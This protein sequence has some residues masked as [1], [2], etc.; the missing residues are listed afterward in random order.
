MGGCEEARHLTAS[1]A[2]SSRPYQEYLEDPVAL[3]SIRTIAVFPFED[4]APQPGFDADAFANKLANQLA[5]HGKIRL[6][7]PREILEI[8]DRENRAA[9][10]HNAEFRERV[11]L[12]LEKSGDAK[13]N[14]GVFSGGDVGESGLLGYH[15]PIKNVDDAV[16]LGRRVKADAIIVGKVSDI[17]SYMRPRLVLDMRLIA[18]GNAESTARAIA[19][20]AQWGVPRPPG[21]A[22]GVVYVRQETFD[23]RVG[24][25]G[26]DVS[27]YGRSRHI[28]DHPYDTEIF[29][30]SMT[31]YYDVVA[32]RLARAYMEARAK[33]V[34]EAE[35]R[36][37]EAARASRLDQE[38]A[39]RR[40]LA[41]MDRDS[42]I[43][44]HET[45]SR[46]EDY[47][48]QSFPARRGLLGANGGDR[49]IQS[50]RADGRDLRPASAAERASRD[51]RIPE[52][53][54]GRGLEGYSAMSDS[55]FPDADSL[56]EMN[57]GDSRDRG[58]RPDYYNHANPRRSAPLYGQGEFTGAR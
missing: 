13:G 10:R 2:S 40:M 50:W 11:S 35:K 3:T 9:R 43:P 32:D 4:G 26:R 30:R 47:F 48:D 7:Y 54:R 42:R 46:G 56:L 16:R 14:A 29:V 45:D 58:W 12:G 25:V 38:A 37:R 51:G 53:E 19:E 22:R 5:A 6:I 41:L 24:S 21:S 55:A 23:S 27:R 39:V 52:N 15:N 36:A 34:R 31:H 8:A 28:D 33:A 18:T 1:L 57:L 20:L 44:D 49:R 17:D